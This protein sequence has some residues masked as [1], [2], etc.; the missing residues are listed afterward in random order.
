M[1]TIQ[2]GEMFDRVGQWASCDGHRV[3]KIKGDP[4]FTLAR[5][6]VAAGYYPS[7]PL[8]IRRGERVC[9]RFPTLADAAALVVVDPDHGRSRPHFGKFRVNVFAG[10]D[11]AD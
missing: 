8:E 3:V 7:E 2:I 9:L 5:K 1:I 4:A 6:L 10:G 11:E